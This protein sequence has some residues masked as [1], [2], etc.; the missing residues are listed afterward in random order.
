MAKSKKNRK[1][2]SKELD[3]I[4]ASIE[5]ILSQYN[6]STPKERKA[7]LKG[8]NKD[9][10][11]V[12]KRW[13]KSQSGSDVFELT[14]INRKIK[15]VSE[16]SERIP[17]NY[18]IFDFNIKS[19]Y[20]RS[21]KNKEQYL[22]GLFHR[23]MKSLLSRLDAPKNE[24]EANSLQGLI[25]QYSKKIK[26]TKFYDPEIVENNINKLTNFRNKLNSWEFSEYLKVKKSII[27]KEIKDK[28]KGREIGD[29]YSKEAGE[30]EE[31]YKAIEKPILV[32]GL[33]VGLQFNFF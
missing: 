11:K 25:T 31:I 9:K 28:E 27:N 1:K 19:D 22:D 8:L 24:S 15:R 30:R 3:S 17:I 29:Y 5:S 4:N 6:S 23:K 10:K 13:I 7:V 16:V 20:F 21:I 18:G 2:V 26:D 33:L 14:S 32:E 12:I